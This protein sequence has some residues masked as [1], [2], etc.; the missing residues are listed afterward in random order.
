MHSWHTLM[1][2]GEARQAD[3]LREAQPRYRPVAPRRNHLESLS[4]I[5]GFLRSHASAL[6][7]RPSPGG[8]RRPGL[9][10]NPR[11]NQ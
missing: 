4:R 5:A 9:E 3:L 1:L 11:R 6:V 7:T 2:L 10:L 8:R